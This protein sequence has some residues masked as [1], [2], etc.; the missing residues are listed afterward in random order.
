MLTNNPRYNPNVYSDHKKH[1]KHQFYCQNDKQT[2]ITYQK[3]AYN[4]T[5]S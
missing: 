4:R 5:K 1:E 3:V 2:K